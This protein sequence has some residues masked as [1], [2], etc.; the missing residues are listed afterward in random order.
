[1]AV[2]YVNYTVAVIGTYAWVLAHK[3]ESWNIWMRHGIY[4][5]VIAHVWSWTVH[6]DVA[7]F[8]LKSQ[9]A[10]KFAIENG[11]YESVMQ[12]TNGPHTNE[13]WNIRMRHGAYEWAM[14]HTNSAWLIWIRHGTHYEAWHIWMRRGTYGWGIQHMSVWVMPHTN[15]RAHTYIYI[16]VY[17]CIYTTSPILL[18]KSHKFHK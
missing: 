4:K 2:I 14:A 5:W 7:L 11:S 9:L 12:R 6:H 1:M 18:Q 10:T 13:L 8:A 17:I 3:N 15:V 16:H